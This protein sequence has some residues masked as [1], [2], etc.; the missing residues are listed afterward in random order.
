MHYARVIIASEQQRAQATR[1]SGGV[2][3]VSGGVRLAEGKS[4]LELTERAAHLLGLRDKQRVGVWRAAYGMRIG[5]YVGIMTNK[6]PGALPG[7]R[8][9]R[10]RRENYTALTRMA[11]EMGAVAFVFAVEDVDFAQRRV[12]GYARV[13]GRWVPREYPLPDVVYNRVPD[14]KS[15]VSLPVMRF[16]QQIK[17]LQPAVALFNPKFLNKWE[18]YGLLAKQPELTPFVPETCLYREPKDLVDMLRKHDMVYLK[19]QDTFAGRGIMRVWR[20]G[21]KLV[22]SYKDGAKYRHAAY[23]GTDA[24]LR[25]FVARR[26]GSRYLL[27]EGLRLAKLRGAIFDVRVLVQKNN[28]GQWE[29]TG[30]GVRVAAP[31]G[32]TTH[33]PNGGHI[34]PLDTVLNEVFGESAGRPQ[35]LRDEIE[36]LALKVAPA[37]ERG[38]GSLFGEMSMD[39]GITEAKKCY[40]F[41]ANA[42][43]MKFDEPAIRAKSLRRL[44]EFSRY[45]AGYQSS[46]GQSGVSIQD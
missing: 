44:V 30:I 31:G 13:G 38:V 45:L 34:A 15:E 1:L 36:A 23:T 42:K 2:A 41:E 24:L 37:I 32:I 11:G 27:Q 39:I 4:A 26:A 19:P 28:Q 7:F 6:R 40:F 25:A 14:R 43:P 21:Q 33:V 22:L 9:L 18:L 35:G 46:G 3:E 16:K 5:P 20:K 17:R 29:V 12:L 8:G 10:G